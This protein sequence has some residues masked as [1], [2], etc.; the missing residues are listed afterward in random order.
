MTVT[1]SSL[2]DGKEKKAM[3]RPNHRGIIA[4]S[5][6]EDHNDI[7]AKASPRHALFTRL[8]CWSLGGGVEL[9]ARQLLTGPTPTRFTPERHPG[10]ARLMSIE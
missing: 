9:C 3:I 2:D 6:R 7:H 4:E 10:L 5:S 1:P 8:E